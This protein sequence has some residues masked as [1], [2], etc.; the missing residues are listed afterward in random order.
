[1]LI[2]KAQ[3]LGLTKEKLLTET[4][5]LINKE[6]GLIPFKNYE[7]NNNLVSYLNSLQKKFKNHSDLIQYYKSE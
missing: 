3:S 6:L 7:N 1:M 2:R 4:K 5:Q